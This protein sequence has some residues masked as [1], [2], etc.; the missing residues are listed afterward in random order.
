M[1]GLIR[2]TYCKVIDASATRPWDKMVFDETY[3]EFYMQAQLYNPGNRYQTFQDLIANVPNVEKLHYLTSRVALPYLKQLNQIIPD[4]V[5][6]FGKT[7]LPFTQF[8]FEILASHVEQKDAHRIAIYFYSDPVTWLDTID[9]KLLIA[10]GD[11]REAWQS[12]QEIATDLLA[13]QP[14]LNITAFQPLTHWT[15]SP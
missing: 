15:I 2:L 7:V 12:G 10:C 1:K 8:R 13:V 9:G 5:N 14:S 11:Q 6:V 3:Q 4:V